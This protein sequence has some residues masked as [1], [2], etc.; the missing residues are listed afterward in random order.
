MTEPKTLEQYLR[1]EYADGHI[2]FT[3][4]ASVW[5]HNGGPVEIYIHPTSASGDTT[6]TLIVKGNLVVPKK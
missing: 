1:D 2:E 4:R 5:P 6:P 3:V